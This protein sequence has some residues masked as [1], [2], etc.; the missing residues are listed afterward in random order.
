MRWLM[1][2]LGSLRPAPRH[3]QAKGLY[4][5]AS[6][7]RPAARRLTVEPL[8][9]RSC[10]SIDLL[11]SGAY[12]HSILRY[13]GTSGAFLS[14]FVPP[15]SG[16]L[17]V[18]VDPIIGPDGNLYVSSWGTSS[19]SRYDGT[20]GAF[21]GAVVPSSFDKTTGEWVGEG[22]LRRPHGLAFRN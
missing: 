8:E 18:P 21:L 13:D 6:R 19:V 4:G 17:E 15:E 11:V 1:S 12:N 7:Q 3:T 20:T 5:P 2:V 9:D 22:G 16:G 14:A 10:P